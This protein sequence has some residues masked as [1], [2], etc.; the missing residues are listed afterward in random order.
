MNAAWKDKRPIVI[1]HRGASGYRPEHTLAAYELAIDLGADYIEPDLVST[2][3]G[4]LVVRHENEIGG[5]TDVAAHPEFASRRTTKSIDGYSIT[6]WFTEDFTLPELKTLRARE[7][8]PDI[9][10]ENTRYDGQFTIPTL[11]EVLDLVDRKSR[12]IGRSI[13]IYPETKHPSYFDSTG[14]SLEEPLV[15]LL[16]ANGYGGRKPNVFIQSFESGNLEE[17]KR[18]TAIPLIQLIN[19]DQHD[20]VQPA[21]LQKIKKYVDGVGVSKNLIFPR[22]VDNH[23]L[24]AT[25]LVSD[26]HQAGLLVHVWTFRNEDAFLPV[27]LQGNP[28]AEY[29]LFIGEG[30]DGVF[31]DHPDTAVK[32]LGRGPQPHRPKDHG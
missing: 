10:P 23:L 29:A 31:S 21:E 20:L 26:A 13:G 7:R 11:Q 2:R 5:T 16:H 32:A 28:M 17:L 25:P 19:D 4:V 6:G 1:A 24:P 3:E 30:I 22:D 9:R 8:I 15:E 14:L 27:N 12:E 18:M